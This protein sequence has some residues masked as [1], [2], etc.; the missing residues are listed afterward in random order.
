MKKRVLCLMLALCLCLSFLFVAC[1]PEEPVEDVPP[2]VEQEKEGEVHQ[3]QDN[4]ASVNPDMPNEQV[5]P[6]STIRH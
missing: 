6:D 3:T 2:V 1:T 4:A 5:D